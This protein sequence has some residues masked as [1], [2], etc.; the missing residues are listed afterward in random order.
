MV[1]DELEREVS[2]AIKKV[3]EAGAAWDRTREE[4][5]KA[6][7]AL[8]ELVEKKLKDVVEESLVKIPGLPVAQPGVVPAA[9]RKRPRK[10]SECALA[11]SCQQKK[12]LEAL[13]IEDVSKIC[14]R[15]K[16]T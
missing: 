16:V 11:K 7:V 14:K 10:C 13:N 12:D 2:Q 3:R 4:F 8:S 5:S 15:G 6:V 9:P 1:N